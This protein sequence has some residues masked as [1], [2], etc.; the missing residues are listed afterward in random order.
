[1][2]SEEKILF[3]QIFVAA[4]RKN[5]LSSTEPS[6]KTNLIGLLTVAIAFPLL[7]LL[8]LLSFIVPQKQWEKF[9]DAYLEL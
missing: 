1:M 4:Y 7:L 3:A 8:W 9:W 2:K 5:S 6:T